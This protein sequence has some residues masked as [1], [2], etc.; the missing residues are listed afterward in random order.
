MHVA[1][2]FWRLNV[3]EPFTLLA[4]EKINNTDVIVSIF[5]DE[6]INNTNVIADHSLPPEFARQRNP[7]SHSNTLPS[8]KPVGR[9]TP[10][11]QTPEETPKESL[12]RKTPEDR[13]RV[14]N[15]P[16][17]LWDETLT[18]A[19]QA[20]NAAKVV[21]ENLA[22]TFVPVKSCRFSDQKK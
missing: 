18:V 11:K 6:K 9:A 15:L 21:V 17:S 8:V 13:Y 7:Y 16:E 22:D 5:D 19:A 2:T 10:P 14:D 1:V 12:P 20:Y 4:D 3:F